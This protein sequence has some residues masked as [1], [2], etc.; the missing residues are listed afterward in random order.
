MIE[1]A[2]PMNVTNIIHN[3]SVGVPSTSNFQFTIDTSLPSTSSNSMRS[4]KFAKDFCEWFYK[5]MNKLQPICAHK[6][7]DVFSER[8]FVGNSS[9]LILMTTNEVVQRMG[10]NQIGAY[11]VLKNTLIEFELLFS[12]NIESGLQLLRGEHGSVKVLCCGNLHKHN[13]YIG[14]YE[15]EFDLVFCPVDELWKI[16]RTKLNLKHAAVAPQMPS[17]PPCEIF[18]IKT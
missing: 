15:Q 17:L 14:I 5:M 3:I 7:G 10:T 6:E 18:E 4:D 13:A 2:P 9:V 11:R 16:L 8:V 1:R 12:P